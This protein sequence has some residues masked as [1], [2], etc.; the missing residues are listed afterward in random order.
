MPASTRQTAARPSPAA[1]AVPS[2]TSVNVIIT[3]VASAT[4]MPSSASTAAH[5]PRRGD[6]PSLGGVVIV[7]P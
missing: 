6:L 1:S 5:M 7:P 4:T 2:E 3:G